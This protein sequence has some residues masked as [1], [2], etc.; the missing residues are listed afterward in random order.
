MLDKKMLEIYSDFLIASTS[1]VTA[2][3]LSKTLDN[4]ITHD[5]VTYFLS[6]KEYSESE[7]WLLIKPTVRDNEIED[8][9]VII[10]D[11][12]GEKPYSSENEIVSWHFS[13]S[14]N[15][16]VKGINIV[17][18]LYNTDNINI[19]VDY[20]VVEK[21]ETY[22]DEKGNKKRK[23]SISKNE[24]FRGML[25]NL[26]FFHHVKFKYILGDS[27]FS[28]AENMKYVQ[29]NVEKYFIFAIK[30]NRGIVFN[31]SERTNTNKFIQVK[32]ANIKAG[33]IYKVWVKGISFP[34]LLVKQ[35]FKNEDESIGELYMVTNDTLLDYFEITNIYQKRWNIEEYHKSIKSNISLEKSPT[36]KPKTQKNHIFISIYSYLKL[37]LL[38]IKNKLNHFALKSKI[39]IKAIKS[40]MKE[41]NELKGDKKNN[42]QN[43]LFSPV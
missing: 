6:K 27:W 36:K 39:Y 31:E 9:V 2:T 13:H 32:N 19:P 22:I 26:K 16:T 11:T 1:L 18:L 34:L 28:S 7:Y 21:D 17:S 41:I 35:I 30:S 15:R 29:N 5:Q 23:S 33:V 8:G 24:L 43:I 37:E 40:A 12:I 10:D 3:A 25:Y 20:R 42:Q 38:S 4:E 14:K